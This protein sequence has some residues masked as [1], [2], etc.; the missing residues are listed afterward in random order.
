MKKVCQDGAVAYMIK[1][2]GGASCGESTRT[3]EISEIRVVGHRDA[4][5]F[6]SHRLLH[7][8]FG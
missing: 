3:N 1:V 8:R 2:K 6:D 7:V 5:R 4:E